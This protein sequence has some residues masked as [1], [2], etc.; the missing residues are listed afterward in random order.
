MINQKKAQ[1]AV[2]FLV[3]YGWALLALIAVIGV[4]AYAG[5]GDLTSQVPSSCQ[6]GTFFDC[7]G[8]FAIE[9]GSFVFELKNMHGKDI[10]ITGVGC[11][12]SGAAATPVYV[13]LHDTPVGP[14]ET[15]IIACDSGG[16]YSVDKGKGKFTATIIY[17]Y[18]ELEALPRVSTGEIVVAV[19]SDITRYNDAANQAIPEE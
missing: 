9:D 7:V 12:F 1:A 17:E 4:L 11:G 19:D 3:T 16:S 6:L 18:D 8:Y 10:I 14:S 2:E 15:A 13:K 5:L